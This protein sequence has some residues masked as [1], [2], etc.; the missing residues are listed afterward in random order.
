[1]SQPIEYFVWV[2]DSNGMSYH[3]LKAVTRKRGEKL[4]AEYN[5]KLPL[6]FYWLEPVEP[7]KPVQPPH[8]K[9]MLEKA[10]ELWMES[11]HMLE[12]ICDSGIDGN[13]IDTMTLLKIEDL[14]NIAIDLKDF[15]SWPVEF[16]LPP[17]EC[18]HV[19]N[20]QSCQFCQPHDDE[21]E[22]I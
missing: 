15:A 2:R 6:N 20:E 3:G 18:A 5:K 22:L 16:A 14:Q 9:A 19:T 7:V 1:M 12:E 10:Q 11:R 21:L 8:A 4:V 13:L 17:G